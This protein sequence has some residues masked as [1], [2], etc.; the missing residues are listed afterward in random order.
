MITADFFFGGGGVGGD[1]LQVI[2][3]KGKKVETVPLM[4]F[5]T[6]GGK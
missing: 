2:H 3:F 6:I 5:L 4:L 1:G